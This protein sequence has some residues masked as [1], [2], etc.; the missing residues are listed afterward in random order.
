MIP[1]QDVDTLVD[2]LVN[3]SSDEK[4][5]NATGSGSSELKASIVKSS[6]HELSSPIQSKAKSGTD[7]CKEVLGSVTAVPG[8]ST[9]ASTSNDIS[10][11]DAG[12][13]DDVNDD[14]DYA[15]ESQEASDDNE[16][17]ICRLIQFAT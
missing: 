4:G 8:S 3:N 1:N 14:P 13:V 11:D 17:D 6:K 16:D 9:S 15:P 7:E 10:V 5:P 2:E 12:N